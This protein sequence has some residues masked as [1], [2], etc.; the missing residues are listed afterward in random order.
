MLE[1]P[2]F[3]LVALPAVLLYGLSKGGFGG[4]ALL[5]IPMLVLVM[6]P[7]EAT[8]FI[9]PILLVQDV[10]SVH[11]FGRVYDKQS[12][13][14]LIPGGILGLVAGY[15]VATLV[16]TS[17]IKGVVGAL[18]IFFCLKYWLLSPI[19]KITAK[20]H[21]TLAAAFWGWLSGVTT[22]IIHAG[23]T[24]F[25]I[26]MLPRK[27]EKATYI[28]TFTLFFALMNV[29]KI[30]PFL[31]LGGMTWDIFKLSLVFIP[32][33]IA[34]NYFGIYLVTKVSEARFRQI[35]YALTFCVGCKLLLDTVL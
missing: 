28:G 33:A 11:R 9:L 29:L 13:S 1:N 18:A 8:A 21:N 16:T 31:A 23:G 10:V 17:V 5:S 26:Y 6:P 27:F 15:F 35:I 4:A 3:Y 12:L 22:F 20:P 25:N 7:L 30:P 2:Q 14:A 32:F 24:S 34:A 19:A